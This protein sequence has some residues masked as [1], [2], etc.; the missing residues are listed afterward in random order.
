MFEPI[1]C[2]PA[3]SSCATVSTLLWYHAT[4]SMNAK[5][6]PTNPAS[7]NAVKSVFCIPAWYSAAIAES[8]IGYG[9]EA[10][11]SLINSAFPDEVSNNTEGPALPVASQFSTTPPWAPRE[12]SATNDEAPSSPASSPSVKIMTMSLRSGSPLASARAVSS[13]AATE[14]LSSDAPG[15]PK[16]VS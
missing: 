6:S 10:A 13:M 14:D 3:V 2:R 15:L 5:L 9:A 11:N 7:R 1:C 12:C 8:P 4:P 16:V